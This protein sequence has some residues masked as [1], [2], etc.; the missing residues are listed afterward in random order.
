[1]TIPPVRSEMRILEGGF[2]PFAG[3][4]TAKKVGI[5]AGSVFIGIPLVAV[6]ISFGVVFLGASLALAAVAAVVVVP[7]AALGAMSSGIAATKR[8]VESFFAERA[9]AKREREAAIAQ[10][11]AF[12]EVSSPVE[13]L[14]STLPLYENSGSDVGAPVS[15]DP[16]VEQAVPEEVMVPAAPEE[17]QE[18]PM[19]A[20]AEPELVEI[21]EA[22]VPPVLAEE[23]PPPEALVEENQTEE[24]RDDSDALPP[25][26][27]RVVEEAEEQVVPVQQQLIEPAPSIG[28]RLAETAGRAVLC[29][30]L[31]SGIG[32]YMG[33]RGAAWTGRTALWAGRTLVVDAPV[34]AVGVTARVG[35]AALSGTAT[36]GRAVMSTAVATGQA[37]ATGAATAGRGALWAGRVV[38]IDTPSAALGVTARAGQAAL[39]GAAWVGSGMA[40]GAAALGSAALSGATWVAQTTSDAASLIDG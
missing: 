37:A 34:A 15:S 2:D 33:V 22:S 4:S 16:V 21:A 19:S 31:I 30:L 10:S 23:V 8:A 7:L 9:E 36:A 39:S 14:P 29:G 38:L 17:I 12:S 5:V 26:V 20:V 1:M 24:I 27:E 13:S 18:D 3:M 28:E 25:R 40:A 6:G 35:Q 11:F 32:L